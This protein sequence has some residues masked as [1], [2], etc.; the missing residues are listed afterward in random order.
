MLEIDVETPAASLSDL[1]SM[2]GGSGAGNAPAA[3]SWQFT[4]GTTQYNKYTILG[5]AL[6]QAGLP[7][8]KADSE[9]AISTV[10]YQINPSTL[11]AADDLTWRFN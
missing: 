9:V 3:I 10:P 5:P 8:E 6:Q 2:I 11:N 7:D 4:I 1:W